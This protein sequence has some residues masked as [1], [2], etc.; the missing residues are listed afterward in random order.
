[1]RAKLP[2]TKRKT[3]LPLVLVLVAIP[4]AGCASD[5][6]PATLYGSYEEAKSAP[7]RTIQ[8][9]GDSTVRLKMLV[10]AEKLVEGE[11]DQDVV[12][13]LYDSASDQPITDAD[14]A[15]ESECNS[16]SKADRDAFCAW[17]PSMGHGT[18]PEVSPT[19]DAHGVYKGMTTWSMSNVWQL[20][21]N[22][23]IS[24]GTVLDFN[25]EICVNTCEAQGS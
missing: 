9:T 8:P 19:H 12:F 21:I 11:G 15:A 18:A 16:A 6:G 22:P 10:P 13:L 2:D 7:G 23:R 25:V 5:S 20:S 17:M 1:M 14:F 3:V 4:L 24:D